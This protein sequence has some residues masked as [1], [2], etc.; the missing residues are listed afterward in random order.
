MSAPMIILQGITLEEFWQ[1]HEDRTRAIVEK[2]ISEFNSKQEEKL[3]SSKEVCSILRISIPTLRSYCKAG[4]IN[5]LMV[6]SKVYF[7][8]SEIDNAIVQLK[9]FLKS[10]G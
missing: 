3:L 9:P 8:K 5:K 1:Q 4:K 2:V 7:K 10:T 6:G